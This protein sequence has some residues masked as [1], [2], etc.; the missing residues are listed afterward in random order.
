MKFLT[1][2]KNYCNPLHQKCYNSVVGIER[3]THVT[4]QDGGNNPGSKPTIIFYLDNTNFGTK[5]IWTF[6]T[7]DEMEQEFHRIKKIL[8]GNK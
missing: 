8:G 2:N 3:I 7:K 5:S 1:T 4:A 6:D